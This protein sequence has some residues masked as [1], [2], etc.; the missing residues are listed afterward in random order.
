MLKAL[1]HTEEVKPHL[2]ITTL[3][4]TTDWHTSTPALSAQHHESVIP[5]YL[6]YLR[7]MTR[8][9]ETSSEMIIV[10][11]AISSL[12][13]LFLFL[14]EST[15][16]ERRKERKKGNSKFRL[17]FSFSESFLTLLLAVDFLEVFLSCHP[18]SN[19]ACYKWMAIFQYFTPSIMKEFGHYSCCSSYS[20]CTDCNTLGGKYVILGSK[21]L[22]ACCFFLF[23][24]PFY[25]CLYREEKVCAGAPWSPWSPRPTGPTGHPRNTW[26]SRKHRCGACRTPWTSRATGTSGRSR[27]SRYKTWNRNDTMTHCNSKDSGQRS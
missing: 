11:E 15:G 26:Y 5:A 16:K 2:Q 1:V 19:K 21:D 13:T 17:N 27:S 7:R 6:G 25:F 4:D 3:E 14:T 23:A 10:Q 24:N 20:S 22:P 9:L 18:K 8:I 12:I